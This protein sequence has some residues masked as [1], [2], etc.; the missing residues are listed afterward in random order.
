MLERISDVEIRIL[1]REAEIEGKNYMPPL[2]HEPSPVDEDKDD[3]RSVESDNEYE[4][5]EKKL[6]S[7]Q[8]KQFKWTPETEA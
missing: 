7:A 5:L 6:S 8:I 4:A 1:K 2:Q 3:L